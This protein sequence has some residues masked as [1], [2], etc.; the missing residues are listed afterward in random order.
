ML[1]AAALV[2]VAAGGAKVAAC[3]RWRGD[4]ELT[5]QRERARRHASAA[6]DGSMRRRRVAA[7][8]VRKQRRGHSSAHGSARDGRP[9]APA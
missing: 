7:K 4:Y 2:R 5:R 6:S 3:M 1:E 9:M 8:E